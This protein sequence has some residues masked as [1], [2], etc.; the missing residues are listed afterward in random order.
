MKARKGKTK[1]AVGFFKRLLKDQEIRL[2][3]EEERARSTIAIGVRAARAQ[4]KLTQTQL[5]K[6]IGSTQSVIA[7]L[8]SGTDS[9]VPSLSLLARIAAACN[10]TLQLGFIFSRA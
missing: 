5:A 4:A 8:E 1:A 9:R 2:F 10:G 6:K 7:R 3:Y